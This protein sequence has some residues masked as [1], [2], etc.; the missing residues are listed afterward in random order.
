MSNPPE[1]YLGLDVGDVR[2]GV[3]LSRSGV[4]AEPLVTITRVGRRQTIDDLNRIVDEHRI[5]VCVVGLP[6]LESGDSGEQVEK[7]QA[8]VRSLQRR[9][10]RLRFVFEDERY[11][12][13]DAREILGRRAGEK[14]AVDRVAAAIILQ[15][16]LDR[17]ARERASNEPAPAEQDQS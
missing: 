4:I 3:A 9:L 13:A 14:G 16:Y 7:T 17:A 10:P 6:R 5:T 2:I 12:S 8:F 11:S 1:A 15:Q